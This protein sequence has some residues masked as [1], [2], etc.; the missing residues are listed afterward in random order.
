MNTNKKFIHK[1]LPSIIYGFR[2][3]MYDFSKNRRGRSIII[4]ILNS[5][6][7]FTDYFLQ[8]QKETNG[9]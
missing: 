5:E 6:Q 7:Y 3:M 1:D 9:F 8:F 4:L 2:R